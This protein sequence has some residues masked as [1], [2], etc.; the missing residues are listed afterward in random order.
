[1]SVTV[2]LHPTQAL[3]I[4]GETI[5]IQLDNGN[6]FPFDSAA[7][8]SQA[9]ANNTID[10]NQL[11]YILMT[12]CMARDPALDSPAVWNGRQITLNAED[13]NPLNVCKIT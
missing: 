1:M 2:K 13:Q 7:D 9:L 3:V 5:S 4:D 8:F 6:M 12:H 11:A 10:P